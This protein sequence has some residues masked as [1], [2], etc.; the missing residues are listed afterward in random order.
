MTV[1]VGAFLGLLIYY[2]CWCRGF[3]RV[4]DIL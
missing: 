3:L 1:G 4:V 2:D